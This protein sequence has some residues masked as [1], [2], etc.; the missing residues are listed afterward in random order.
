MVSKLKGKFYVTTA[1]DY[2]NANPHVGHAIE[3]IQADVLARWNRIEGKNVFFL[4]GTD[5]HGLKIQNAAQAAKLEPKQFVD[6]TAA[7]FKDAWQ[8]LN[9]S[10]DRFIRTTD[11]DHEKAVAQLIKV[12]HK[13]GDIYKGVYEGLYCVGCERFYT[14]KELD[15]GLCK[16]HRTKCEHTKEPGYFFKLGKYQ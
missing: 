4:T 6:K 3:K 5:E 1:I 11:A 13:N 7:E 8:M 9:I 12:V 15:N 16:I 10:H 2:P 14:E